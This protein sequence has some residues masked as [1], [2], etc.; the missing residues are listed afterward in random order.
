VA[1]ISSPEYQLNGRN[2]MRTFEQLPDKLRKGEEGKLISMVDFQ[3]STSGMWTSEKVRWVTEAGDEVSHADDFARDLTKCQDFQTYCLQHRRE[4]EHKAPGDEKAIQEMAKKGFAIK[5]SQWNSFWRGKVAGGLT[6]ALNM[7]KPTSVS[8]ENALACGIGKLANMDLSEMRVVIAAC[9]DGGEVTQEEQRTATSIIDEVVFDL[10]R[11][12]IRWAKNTAIFLTRFPTV[13]SLV[14][15]L[16]GNRN[17][18]RAS[19]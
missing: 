14:E 4:F 6:M 5:N 2:A 19:P 9:I 18:K 15:S 7:Q 8:P 3:G 16:N 17:L 13:E 10:R 11:R 1:L 12:G